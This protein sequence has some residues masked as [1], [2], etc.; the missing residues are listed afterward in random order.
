MFPNLSLAREEHLTMGSDGSLY[1]LLSISAGLLRQ[2]AY[3]LG[4]RVCMIACGTGECQLFSLR[5]EPL[6]CMQE[7]W[8]VS[9]SF[10]DGSTSFKG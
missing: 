8:T 1:D 3:R 6:S 9:F 10:P 2:W 4:H 5:Y 7:N